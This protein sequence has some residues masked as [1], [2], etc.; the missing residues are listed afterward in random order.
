MSEVLKCLEEVIFT[1]ITGLKECEG[2]VAFV[3]LKLY[4]LGWLQS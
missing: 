1:G 4:F 3:T 2:D